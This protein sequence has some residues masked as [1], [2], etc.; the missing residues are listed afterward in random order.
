MADRLSSVDAFRSWMNLQRRS[1]RWAEDGV[2]STVALDARNGYS[3]V[4]NGKSDGNSRMDASTQVMSGLVGALLHPGVHRAMVIGLGTGSTAGWLGA[5]P[6]IERVD[7]AELEPAV[8]EV[9]RRSALANATDTP[10]KKPA[11]ST[12]DSPGNTSRRAS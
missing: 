8:L 7:V 12:S 2:E 10:E 3:F 11:A 1:I 9:A 6:D 5:L 4:V